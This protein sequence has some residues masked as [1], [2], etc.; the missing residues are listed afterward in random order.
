MIMDI[1]DIEENLEVK[2]AEEILPKMYE[3]A[4]EQL[5][6]YQPIEKLPDW[7]MDINHLKNQEVLKDFIS[8][9]VEELMEGYES[10]HEVYKYMESVGWNIDLL[11]DE[12][13]VDILNHLANANEEQ[14]D[15]LGFFF[16]L[17]IY[18]NILPEDIISHPCN[19]SNTKHLHGIFQSGLKLLLKE[20]IDN[21][22]Y[23]LEFGGF[24]LT[25]YCEFEYRSSDHI[26]DF[27]EYTSYS[28]G[29]NYLN[30]SLMVEQEKKLFNIILDLN[31]ARNL[32][33]SR[34][35]KQT[36]VLTKELD[37]QDALV[38]AFYKYMGYLG[39]FRVYPEGLLNLFFKKTRLNLWRIKSGY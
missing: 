3:L 31:K 36:Q 11:K 30:A 7:P 20:D 37:F 5:K 9:V 14:A 21:D 16:S 19:T 24:E 6:A 34:P 26:P 28:P 35:W 32:L 1:R 23:N 13:Y 33:K 4:V 25:N 12:E 15:A 27:V 10:L 38:R 22:L 8:R 17:L 18:S 29:F 2:S 39:I